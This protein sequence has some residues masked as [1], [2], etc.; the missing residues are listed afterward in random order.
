MRTLKVSNFSCIEQASM[1]LG[2]LTVIIGP[3]A[4]GKSVLCKLAFFLF[5]CAARQREALFKRESLD[6]FKTSIKERF[7][8]WFPR[9]AWGAKQFKIELTAG[10]YSVTL[11]RKTY[12]GKISDD[13]RVKLSPTF[14]VN[15]G[16][17]LADR[18]RMKKPA[19]DD[20]DFEADY[21]YSN[22]IRSSMAKLFGKDLVATQAFV[23]AGRSFFTSLGKAI[24]AFEHGRDPLTLR[25]G[26]MYTSYR[27]RP[28]T[29]AR[30]ANDVSA[31]K[32]IQSSIAT[33]LGGFVERDGEKEY[34]RLSDGRMIPLSAMS[35]GQQE[36]LPL[37][38]MLPWIVGTARDD[39]LCYI[40][41]PE[42]HLFPSAQSQ[43]IESLVAASNPSG[44]NLVMTTHS[45]YVLTKIN[46]LLR[47]GAVSRRI[48][49]DKKHLLEAI[50]PRRAWLVARNV[51][52]YAIQDHKLVSIL[53]SDGLV[54]ADYL[55]EISE[56]L[57]IEFSKL[58]ELEETIV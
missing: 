35:S 3:Q 34:F 14:E 16:A 48:A 5:E 25:F 13:F 8:E 51:R 22:V 54:D 40:E 56:D 43:L 53:D 55:D 17:L 45:P 49:D 1:E 26:R 29:L 36:L 57:G 58:L 7:V 19:E 50:V 32:A 30:N 46:N 11:S 42:A 28:P 31:L 12:A 44:A 37:A 21:R 52:A 23:P 24:A 41:E 9:E 38:V 39:R 47:A 10:D 4:S 20:D 6:K 33:L 2:R 27:E 15:Y 18:E